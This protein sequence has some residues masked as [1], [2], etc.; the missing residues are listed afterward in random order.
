MQIIINLFREKAVSLQDIRHD[1]QEN[2][3]AT[4]VKDLNATLKNIAELNTSI[5]NSQVL[6][7]PALELMDERN[8]LLDELGSYLPINVNYKQKKIGE[9]YSVQ[10]LDVTFTDADGMSH[11]LISDGRY[12]EFRTDISGQPVTLSVTDADG[13]TFDVT[14]KP[15]T[16][17]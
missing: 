8:R 6:G 7:N 5:K 10:V 2:F 12:S 1:T 14:D 9:G 13:Y 16:E 4:D 15:L 17:H 3:K 11:R